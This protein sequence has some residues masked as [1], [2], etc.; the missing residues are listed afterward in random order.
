MTKINKAIILAGGWGTRR[1]PVTKTIDKCMLPVVNRPTIDYVIEDCIKAGIS[2]IYIVVGEHS[3]QIE[4]YY[5][6]NSALEKYL[7]DNG[8]EDKIVEIT[9]PEGV[10]FH[11]VHQAS[12][13]KYGTAY[14]V[15]LA[16]DRAG[17]D[18]PVAIMTGDDFVYDGEASNLS[19]LVENYSEGDAVML[20]AKV[21]AGDP[22]KFGF[23]EITEDLN[24]I[25][26]TE[27]V[28]VAEAPS[29]LMNVSRYIMPPAL[30]KEVVTYSESDDPQTSSGEYY[31]TTVP[32][33]NFIAN[34]G[35][36]KVVPARGKYLESGTFEGWLE[37]NRFVSGL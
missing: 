3:T 16:L 5:S 35:R 18:E 7:Q 10:N 20:G 36:V 30:L 33:D 6:H 21:D 24:M 15:A 23:L 14:A 29:D 11:F 27:S 17:V 13:G 1:L 22:R 4:D 34:G 26:M 37:A 2:N 25:R 9:P 19:L 28:T 12:N 31:L 32:F 8:K